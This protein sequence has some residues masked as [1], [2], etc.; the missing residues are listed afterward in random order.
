[1]PCNSIIL[2]YCWL[3]VAVLSFLLAEG[4]IS[5][6]QLDGATEHPQVLFAFAGMGFGA[7][8]DSAFASEMAKDQLQ[9]DAQQRKL[10]RRASLNGFTQVSS[11]TKST[12]A[13]PVELSRHIKHGLKPMRRCNLHDN[14]SA[15][16]ILTH[17]Q[18]CAECE[19]SRQTG[20]V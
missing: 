8:Y 18:A 20:R 1:M 13:V 12:F 14:C 11:A 4:S 6:T 7:P 16:Q 19:Q 15:V 10:D 2:I 17:A 5:S 3:R 9:A